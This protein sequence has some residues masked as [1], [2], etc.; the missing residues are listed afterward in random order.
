M[1]VLAVVEP[2][3]RSNP[4]ISG[5]LSLFARQT[6]ILISGRGSSE[7]NNTRNDLVI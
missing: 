3:H 2:D 1:A 4:D 6:L 7:H 5:G